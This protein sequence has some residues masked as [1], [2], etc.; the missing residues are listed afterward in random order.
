MDFGSKIA[1]TVDESAALRVERDGLV[2]ALRLRTQTVL[3]EGL[4]LWETSD[5]DMPVIIPIG[6]LQVRPGEEISVS[7]HYFM[8]C[9]YASLHIQV[10]GRVPQ[11]KILT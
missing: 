8:G 6:P 2:N 1:I 9:G 10:V 11:C 4:T 3:C 7:I 5:R